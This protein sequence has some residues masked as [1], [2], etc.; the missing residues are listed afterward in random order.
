MTSL[1][2]LSIV[3]SIGL[4]QYASAFTLW[5][6]VDPQGLSGVLN[7]STTCIAAL[8]T[9]LDCEPNLF[10][11]TSNVDNIYWSSSNA[12]DL[13]TTRCIESSRKWVDEV[14]GSC[15]GEFLRSGDREVD[16]ETLATRF[17]AGLDIAC[18]KSSSNQW[19]FV[20]S[21]E[22]VGSDVIRPDCNA[23]PSDP[24]CIN[25]A[26]V[27]AENSRMANI[28]DDDLLCSE[29]FLKLMHAR[30]S[31]EFLPDEDHSD[32]LVQE[33]QDIQ[34]VCQTTIAAN[35]ATRSLPNYMVVLTPTPSFVEG[36]GEVFEPEP[37]ATQMSCAADQIVINVMGTT[38][39][40]SMQACNDIA[41]QYNVSTGSL[42][43]LTQN[44][45]CYVEDQEICG[46]RGCSLFHVTKG[47][48][49]TSIAAAVSEG[50]NPINGA[51]LA[52]WN[53]N[54]LG[55]CDHLVE[56]QYICVSR[57]GGSY[58]PP[59][60]S[61]LPDDNDGP[62]RGGPGSTPTLEIIDNP[63]TPI[64]PWLLHEGT[65]KECT[66]YVLVSAGANCWKV[67]NDARI[68]Q[69]RLFELNPVLGPTGEFC[70]TMIWKDYY[71]C[72]GVNGEGAPIT[73]SRPATGTLSSATRTSTTESVPKPTN[74]QAG[75]PASCNKW[76]TTGD[77][78]SCWAIITDSGVA[79]SDFYAWNP[80]LGSQGENCGTQIWPGYSYCIGVSAVAA[81]TPTASASRTSTTSAPSTTGPAK[82][83]ETQAG[84]VGNCNKFVRAGDGDGC[85]KLAN[86]AGIE[87]ALFYKWN[88]VVG[89]N[90]ENCG[91][92]IWPGYYYCVGVSG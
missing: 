5:P 62:I 71:Y 58:I 60:N 14:G 81:P 29:C 39:N 50:T 4:V 6:L 7:I 11:W 86:D 75:Q 36:P 64:S 56:D 34:N 79:A 42:V 1:K 20:E 85:W 41:R 23:D 28:Y 2:S 82:P 52:T 92:Q 43:Y 38:S 54:I 61:S 90:G 76:H 55:A 17:V 26:N 80:V 15:D 32:Y 12:S 70:N 77:G 8:N 9:T 30:I 44:E 48:T 57:P 22:W 67:A 13:C 3:L 84:I 35:I 73:T 66:R 65:P 37:E 25:P 33:F 68:T 78:A 27:S 63:S 51:Q 24:W 59:S 72:V 10:Q 69:P 45:A 89:A 91:T 18:L 47:Q 40:N 21:Q 83:S 74:T 87:S 46:P 88:P 16:A 53:P 19:C 49:C 31:S